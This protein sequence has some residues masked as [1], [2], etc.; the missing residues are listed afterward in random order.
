MGG[1]P[2][3]GPGGQRRVSARAVAHAPRS[4]VDR[5]QGLTDGRG[6]EMA[7]SDEKVAPG[8]VVRLAERLRDFYASLPESEKRAFEAFC[9]GR[10]AEDEVAEVGRFSKTGLNISLLRFHSMISPLSEPTS[11]TTS[12]RILL[13]GMSLAVIA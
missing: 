7:D 13:P 9:R 6:Q 10:L 5:A 8:V 3:E 4:G 12:S 1:G 2:E 11:C